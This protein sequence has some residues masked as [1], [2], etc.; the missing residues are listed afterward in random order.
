MLIKISIG[1]HLTAHQMCSYTSMIL[2]LEPFFKAGAKREC[3]IEINIKGLL[4]D[5][6]LNVNTFLNSVQR[7]A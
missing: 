6:C 1:D 5:A 2:F 4:A 3:K 7:T